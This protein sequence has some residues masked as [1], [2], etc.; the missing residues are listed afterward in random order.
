MNPTSDHK[1]RQLARHIGLRPDQHV[2]DI[3]S[4]RCGPAL[5]FAREF[6]C[7]VTAVEPYEPFMDD[8]KRLVDEAG[9]S[10]RFEF[11]LAKGADFVIEPERYDVAMCLG[12]TWAWG[13][14]DGTLDA[15]VAAVCQDGHVAAG[16]GFRRPEQ[17][18]AG[19][20]HNWTLSQIIERFQRRGLAV[21]SL[22]RS[23]DDDWDEYSSV[24]V[25]N[26]LDWIRDNPTH[27]DVD[28]VRRWRREHAVELATRDMGWAIVSGRKTGFA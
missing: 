7:R 22:I 8:A 13:S 10:D 25:A 19:H 14:L 27:E 17:A 20:E 23:S 15:L 16:E 9:L 18:E 5:L 3:G 28:E 24:R 4:G 1:L 12:A 26:L 2:L 11:A 6:G 21:I